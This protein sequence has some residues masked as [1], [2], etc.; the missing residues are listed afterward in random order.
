[1]AKETKINVN[2]QTN[3]DNARQELM[4][5]KDSTI[6]GSK[7]FKELEAQI[8]KIDDATQEYADSVS[9]LT[10]AQNKGEKN[11][12]FFSN[13][14]KQAESELKKLTKESNKLESA[15]ERLNKGW[16]DM[17]GGFDEIKSGNLAGGFSS[18]TNGIKG[19]TTASLAFIATP[20]GA[21]IAA[22]TAAVAGGKAIWDYNDALAATNK[23]TEQF[24]GLTGDALNVVDAK[25]QTL[26]SQTGA[27]QE[28]VLRSVQALVTQFGISYDEA[29]DK[30]ETGYMRGGKSAEDF[31]DN[32]AEYSTQFENAGYTAEEMFG[33]IE[34]GA[35]NGVYKDKILDSVKE[36]DIALREMPKDSSDALK[37]AFGSDFV[38]TL[39]NGINSGVIKSK[40]AI[41]MI[42][43]EA[44]KSGLSIQDQATLTA[45]VF[46]SAGEDAGG[47]ANVIDTINL[48]LEKSKAEL[49]AVQ[50]AQKAS[51][52][53][54]T[55]M[56]LAFRDLFGM[57][58]GGFSKM[59]A[60]LMGGVYQGITVVINGVIDMY[61]WFAEL[62]NKSSAFRGVIGSIGAVAKTM[63]NI[64]SA[65]IKTIIS[66]FK[67]LGDLIE[68]VFT[69]NFGAIGGIITNAFKNTKDNFYQA[70]KDSVDAFVDAWDEDN[71][72]LQTITKRTREV[73][74][75][76]SKRGTKTSIENS[77]KVVKNAEDNE[78]KKQA[79]VKKTADEAKKAA[80]ELED[81]YKVIDSLFGD[82]ANLGKRSES[83]I[84]EFNALTT[85]LAKSETEF[86]Q[87]FWLSSGSTP[88]FE[89]FLKIVKTERDKYEKELI[90]L[91]EKYN[92]NPADKKSLVNIDEK[93]FK[94]LKE[95]DVI[96]YSYNEL[97]SK[98][99]KLEV[100]YL[101]NKL[102]NFD[103]IAVLYDKNKTLMENFSTYYN[104][105][106]N[107]DLA[108]LKDSINDIVASMSNLNG[109]EKYNL[110]SDLIDMVKNQEELNKL[111]EDYDKKL[112][113]IQN[114]QKDLS[115]TY[116]SKN[117]SGVNN[118]MSSIGGGEDIVSARSRDAMKSD[119]EAQ[120]RHNELILFAEKS[121]NLRRLEELGASEEQMQ[122]MKDYY[123]QQEIDA[124]KKK[125]DAIQ[126]IDELAAQ[127]RSDALNQT[128]DTLSQAS[129]LFAEHTTAYKVFAIAAATID[130][131]QSAMAA[132]KGMVMT[133]P[134]VWGI[135][136][137]VSAAATSVAFGIKQVQEILKVDTGGSVGGGTAMAN[138]S[139]SPN[140]QFVS[141]GDNQIA[142][143]IA[144][145]E[146]SSESLRVYVTANDIQNG[147]NNQARVRNNSGL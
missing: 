3:A 28:E 122:S 70:G 33:I 111:V 133:I 113:D 87:K 27:S 39:T 7:R 81:A 140:V 54:Q 110:L 29:F 37:Q 137:G 6:E 132:Y 78:K 98:T 56:N 80:K 84:N 104:L 72:K 19:M 17:I 88:D 45:D 24:T 65:N 58:E 130:T 50:E 136:A 38:N 82:K 105:E 92:A 53:A 35:Q 62:Y 128:A 141:S 13:G 26:M 75:D 5:L 71:S 40:D 86:Y 61:N 20:I 89:P 134:G 99:N 143:T 126:Q 48:G 67:T 85:A 108:L 121:A 41:Q 94:R 10:I 103:N 55:D 120:A 119:I 42:G 32:I 147:L 144:S 15:T 34:A 46:K 106:D 60:D 8:K 145:S 74:E 73:V 115:T 66:G 14:V 31:F 117:N 131:Y 4:R 102:K 63:F 95:L 52:D 77:N 1:M 123:R 125:T 9:A 142:Q 2:V 25:T 47:F 36:M 124:E 68:A 49:T 64:V 96:I 18:I 118:V 69:G 83:L 129:G 93:G 109:F 23:T 43:D 11:L 59:K 79:A 114:T 44:K 30:I 16:S 116:L 146:N 107:D 91:Y 139:Q 12:K 138:I 21:A 100:E 51:N 76:E 135:A 57:S 90:D 101:S 127:R 22:V 97:I 112:L